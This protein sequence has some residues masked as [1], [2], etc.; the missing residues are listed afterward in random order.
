MPSACRIWTPTHTQTHKHTRIYM[1]TV[2]LQSEATEF[3][4]YNK[5]GMFLYVQIKK[6][7]ALDY[8]KMI[9][10]DA[11]RVHIVLKALLPSP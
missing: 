6:K 5:V 4:C 10:I 9:N 11:T 7:E 1:I 2:S 3:M 8:E